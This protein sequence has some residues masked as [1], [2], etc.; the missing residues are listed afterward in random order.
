MCLTFT[1]SDLLLVLIVYLACQYLVG[2]KDDGGENRGGKLKRV[3]G[4]RKK[5]SKTRTACHHLEL[6]HWTSGAGVLLHGIQIFDQTDR[7]TDGQ[8]S[9]HCLLLL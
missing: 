3:C 8:R 2:T 9:T 4:G 6:E 7:Q 1:L 5:G